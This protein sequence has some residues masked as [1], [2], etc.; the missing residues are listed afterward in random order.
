M[1]YYRDLEATKDR[2]EIS[3]TAGDIEIARIPFALEDVSH[4][5]PDCDAPVY[6]A[7]IDSPELDD[8]LSRND[9]SLSKLDIGNFRLYLCQTAEGVE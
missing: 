8:L 5:F 9:V 2:N 1:Y 7:D 6:S 4:N 3:V